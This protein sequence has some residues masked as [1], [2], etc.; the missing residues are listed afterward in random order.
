MTSTNLDRLLAAS[1]SAKIF[2]VSLP[3]YVRGAVIKNSDKITDEETL[4]RFADNI[5]HEF[6]S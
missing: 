1:E 6:T 5:M 4:R 3:D 2:Y